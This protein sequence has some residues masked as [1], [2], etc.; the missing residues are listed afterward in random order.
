MADSFISVHYFD[1]YDYSFDTKVYYE[2]VTYSLLD[3]IVIYKLLTLVRMRRLK[4][5]V[6]AKGTN[7][8]IIIINNN[9]VYIIL[10]SNELLLC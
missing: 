4:I 9:N 7:S 8:I 2:M 10:V 5:R 6:N 1:N 3:S